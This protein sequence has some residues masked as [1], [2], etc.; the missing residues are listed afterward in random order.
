MAKNKAKAGK[1]KYRFQ[2]TMPD[3]ARKNA[4]GKTKA[5][6]EAKRQALIE[7][8][9]RIRKEGY[10]VK[11][12]ATKVLQSL[13]GTVAPNTFVGYETKMKKVHH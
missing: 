7:E 4:Y 10:R 2:V 5:E 3:G 1:Y 12:Y 9:D 6:A 8:R 11:E 13:R